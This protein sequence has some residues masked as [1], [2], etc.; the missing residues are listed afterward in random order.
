M[1]ASRP[2]LGGDDA[3]PAGQV[4]VLGGVGDRVAHAGDALLVH[5]VD[6]ELQLVEALEVGRL[7]LVARLD[8]GLET[9]LHQLGE[10]AAEHDLLAEEVGLG[11]LLE[12]GLE[13]AGPGPADGSA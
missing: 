6:D 13:H 5:E 2:C 12:G 1:C 8:E 11:L 9:G 3:G 7:G 10:P 4:A